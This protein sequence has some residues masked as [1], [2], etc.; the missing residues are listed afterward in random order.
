MF[1]LIVGF[2]LLILALWTSP[3]LA[4]D[5]TVQTCAEVL[6]S[7]IHLG[8]RSWR[9]TYRLGE[10]IYTDNYKA[11]F[12][13]ALLDEM[14]ES[15]SADQ[16]SEY[17]ENGK[18]VGEKL[19]QF[20]PTSDFNRIFDKPARIAIAKRT[21]ELWRQRTRLPQPTEEDLHT[22]F[23]SE[24]LSRLKNSRLPDGVTRKEYLKRS[25]YLQFIYDTQSNAMA[26]VIELT[27]RDQKLTN[28]GHLSRTILAGLTGVT[29]VLGTVVAVNAGVDLQSIQSA[30][31]DLSKFGFLMIP[32]SI[33]SVEVLYNVV[34][35]KWS[36]R[37]IQKL[38]PMIDFSSR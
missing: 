35:R 8:Q 29:I 25:F 5:T 37:K 12:A 27:D 2:N 28:Q 34:V 31:V 17:I 11:S 24:T 15:E 36:F 22:V 18:L 19:K 20:G 26:R 30:S 14:K 4:Q 32:T 21:Y 3:V 10:K 7:P 13:Q 1:R 6:E 38:Y 23:D 9:M 33:A 16:Y